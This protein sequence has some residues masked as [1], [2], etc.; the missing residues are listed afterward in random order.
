MVALRRLF[1]IG[2]R[3]EFAGERARREHAQWLTRATMGGGVRAPRIPVRKVS[4]G[5]YEFV[6]NSPDGRE[7]ADAWWKGAFRSTD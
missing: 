3:I 6:R 2:R 5:G 1:G 7:W 4:E